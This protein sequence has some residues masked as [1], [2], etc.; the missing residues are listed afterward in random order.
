MGDYGLFLVV[1]NYSHLTGVGVE[2]GVI[3][4]MV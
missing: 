3:P 2:I 4:I 1:E